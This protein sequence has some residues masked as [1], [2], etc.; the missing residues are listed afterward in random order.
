MI[1]DLRNEKIG[2]K[3]REHSISR[4]P[5]MLIIGNKEVET[6][7]IAVRT[8]DGKDLGQM[9]IDKVIKDVIRLDIDKN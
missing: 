9:S 1:C 7:T 4:V 2:F 8:A 6:S 3:I 5:F